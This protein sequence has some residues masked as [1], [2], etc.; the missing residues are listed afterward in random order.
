M[1]LTADQNGHIEGE[2]TVPENVPSGTKLVAF[3]GDQGSYGETTYTSRGLITTEERRE[4]VLSRGRTDPLAQ[5][6]T[7][8]EARFIGGIDVWFTSKGTKRVLC[9]IRE[10]SLGMPTQTVI[11]EGHLF[12][13]QISLTDATRITFNPVWCVAGTEYAFVLLTDD[14][15]HAVALAELGKFDSVHGTWV[16][17]QPYQIG[18]LLSSSNASTWTAHQDKDLAFRLLAA[19]FT[20]SQSNIVLESPITAENL[21]DI[22]V[23]G[24]IE[25]PT[26]QTDVE[27]SLTE[28]SGTVHK[29]SE[30]LPLAL[31]EK[32]SGN[33]VFKAHLNGSNTASPVLYPG[34]QAVL[35][36]VAEEANYVTRSI[37]T[38]DATKFSVTYEAMTPGTSAVKIYVQ[39]P[40][41]G[42]ETWTQVQLSKG[43]QI[44]SNW[45]ERTHVLM[46]FSGNSTRIK[47]VLKGTVLYRPKVRSLRIIAT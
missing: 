2:I 21:T 18:V 22:L 11:A 27:F 28:T 12:A 47:I 37:P 33:L 1:S 20:G 16:T 15:E 6:F 19:K 36:T 26:S 3:E 42:D 13:N 38:P 9:Q 23:L 35:G 39:D 30:D 29:I 34:L 25:R 8:K 31:R 32:I 44:D 43:I 14:A 24:N 5:T 7:L 46:D 17:A 41:Q 40:S 45:V 4:V 10:T